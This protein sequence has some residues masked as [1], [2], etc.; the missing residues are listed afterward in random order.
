MLHGRVA[1]GHTLRLHTLRGIHHQQRS[2]AGGEGAADFVGKIHVT[3]RVDEV[4]GVELAIVGPVV[5]AHALSLDGDAPLPLDIHAVEHLLRHFAIAQGT[6]Q[7][8][9]LIRQ[10]GLAVIHVGDDGEVTDEGLFAHGPD[11]ASK[12]RAGRRTDNSATS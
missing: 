2:L 9:E 12:I 10:G 1:I 4:E 5:Q 8:N 7:A 11:S 6:A 3:R